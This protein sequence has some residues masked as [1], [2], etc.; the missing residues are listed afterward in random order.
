MMTDSVSMNNIYIYI[1]I[2]L[3]YT[4]SALIYIFLVYTV[5]ILCETTKILFEPLMDPQTTYFFSCAITP[6]YR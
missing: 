3:V 2:F 4:D 5:T 1:Y 6:T